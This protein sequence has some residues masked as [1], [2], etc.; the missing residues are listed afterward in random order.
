MQIV[1]KIGP[2]GPN[3]KTPL[4]N[5]NQKFNFVIVGGGTAGWLTALFIKK[6][7]PWA[8]ITVIASEDIGILGA[9]EGTTPHFVTFLNELGFTTSDIIR[10]ASGTIKSGIKFTNWNGD[11]TSFFHPFSENDDVNPFIATDVYR[12]GNP[13]LVYET[14]AREFSLDSINFSSLNCEENKV[15]FIPHPSISSK[16]SNPLEHFHSLSTYGLHFDAR[17]LAKFLKKNAMYKGI[18]FVDSQVSELINDENGYLTQITTERGDVIKCDFVFDCSGFNRLIIGKHFGAEWKSYSDHLPMKK[19]LAFF[20]KHDNTNLPPYTEAIAMKNGWIWKIPVEN[21]YGCGYVYDSDYV[22]EEDVKKEIEEKYG[23]NI[24]Y[25]KSFSFDAGRYETPWVKNC[26]AIGLSAGFIEPLEATSLWTSIFSLRKH[27]VNNLGAILADNYYINRYNKVITKFHD[28]TKDFIYLHYYTQR[29][30][31]PFWKE[32]KEKNPPTENIQ[33]FIDE[34]KHTIPDGDFL[35]EIN[36]AYGMVS[37]YSVAYGTKL[38]N[39]KKSEHIVRALYSDA[40]RDEYQQMNRKFFN[41]IMLLKK[42]MMDHSEFLQY[43]KV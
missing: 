4:D 41:N 19:A 9:G 42:S 12:D 35:F 22:S 24:E 8:I 20:I 7:Y 30:D 40:R 13:A 26:I 33:K 38:L 34:C 25:G 39:P 3:Q 32:F 11:D 2:I 10:E 14:M 5:K 43:I 6:Y 28:D 29:D 15:N 23:D 17:Q 27:M 31:S 18:K 37:F 21:R 36:M 16:N 1:E